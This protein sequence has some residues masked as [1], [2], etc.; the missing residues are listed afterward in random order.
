MVVRAPL[1]LLP[2]IGFQLSEVACRTRPRIN[3]EYPTIY[4][5][6]AAWV[7]EFLPFADAEA[8][9]SMLE[10]RYPMWDSL[11]YPRGLAER[12]T[13]SSQMTSL[14]FEVD[15]LAVIQQAL[16]GEI[17][18]AQVA[19]HPYGPAYA[20]VFAKFERNMPERVYRRYRQTWQDW[21]GA[22]L[23]ENDYRQSLRVPDFDTYLGVRRISVGLLPYI[24]TAEYVL[25][26]DLTDLLATAHRTGYLPPRPNRHR[27]RN[28]RGR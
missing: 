24:V 5:D 14:A 23:Q 28:R 15:D 7:A 26:L 22:V 8:M 25:D 27:P 9:L 6:N 21:F 3:V 10:C 1:G 4:E 13:H 18:D 16:F 19:D 2:G 12:V 17:V 20:D 11:V